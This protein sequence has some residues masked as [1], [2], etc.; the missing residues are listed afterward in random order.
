MWKSSCIKIVRV[1]IFY[2]A[3]GGGDTENDR[4]RRFLLKSP[5]LDIFVRKIF[6]GVVPSERARP[7]DSEN[8]VVFEI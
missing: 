2:F 4:K 7:E 5:L 8:V 3:K 6:S 1:T